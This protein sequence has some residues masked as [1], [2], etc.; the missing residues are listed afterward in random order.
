[1][2]E[3]SNHTFLVNR[4]DQGL[5][6]R[7]LKWLVFSSCISPSLIVFC[8]FCI[9]NIANEIYRSNLEKL[10]ITPKMFERRKE[11]NRVKT[12]HGIYHLAYLQ[13]IGFVFFEEESSGIHYFFGSNFAVIVLQESLYLRHLLFWEMK[14]QFKA[15][16]KLAKLRW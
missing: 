7:Q 5:L 11:A 14:G 4:R 10:E 2:Y 1:M 13:A 6:Y 3:I 12:S 8:H 9:I 15:G 16:K